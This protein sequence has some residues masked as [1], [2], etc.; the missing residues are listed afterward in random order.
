MATEGVFGPRR[1]KKEK[2]TAQPVA[3]RSEVFVEDLVR[4]GATLR[5][6][7]VVLEK[8]VRTGDRGT[9]RRVLGLMDDRA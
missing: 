3:S 7:A 9:V 2:K 4:R 6:E 8:A 5:S 1:P